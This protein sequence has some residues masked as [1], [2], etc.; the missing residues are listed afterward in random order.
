ME[1]FQNI[2]LK[3][4]KML[5]SKNVARSRRKVS[6]SNFK[7]VRNIGIVWDA[8]KTGEFA[9]LGRFYQRMQD[10][11]IDVT[12]FGY[13]PGKNLPDQYT[14]IRYLRCIRKDEINNFYHPDSSETSSFIK[15]PFDIL[16]D[17]NFDKV[18]PLCCVTSLS[19][20]KF[21][22]GLSNSEPSE[23]PF[24]MMI[25]IKNPVN[26]DSYLAQVVQYL[27]MIKD[28]SIKTIE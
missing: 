21:K 7:N 25:D 18:F 8:S 23:S 2:R 26:I 6:Y 27:E 12:V 10:I 14:A 15:N 13:F 4:G 19:V 17:I 9:S 16:I 22:V 28:K 11:K 3:I 1:L 24:D 5:L 20:A